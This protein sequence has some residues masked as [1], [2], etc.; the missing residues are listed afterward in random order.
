MI[1]RGCD[2][3]SKSKM[4]SRRRRRSAAADWGNRRRCQQR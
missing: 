3:I 4:I 2:T 1:D